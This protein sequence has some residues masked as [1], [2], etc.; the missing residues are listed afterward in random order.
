M[1]IPAELAGCV[2]SGEAV[3][4]LGAEWAELPCPALAATCNGIWLYWIV[5]EGSLFGG[6]SKWLANCDSLVVLTCD[7]GSSSID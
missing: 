2:V 3:G 4:S 1:A 5:A 6:T 7:D